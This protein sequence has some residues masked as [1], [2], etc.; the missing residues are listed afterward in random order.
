VWGEEEGL[1][2]QEVL[3]GGRA[4]WRFP[5]EGPDRS[6]DGSLMLSLSCC[7]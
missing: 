5:L 4:Q 2:G 7:R 6:I 1:V 3:C